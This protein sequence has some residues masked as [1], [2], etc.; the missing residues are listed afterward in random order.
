VTVDQIGGTVTVT[1]RT[2]GTT[3]LH[4]NLG[5]IR[6]SGAFRCTASSLNPAQASITGTHTFE[7]KHH[8][9]TIE[10]VAESSIRATE[11]TFHLTIHL[12]VTKNG[13][14]FFQKQW[15]LSEPRRLL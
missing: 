13:R 2:A 15:T 11:T 4:D 5:T 6:R 3:T 10:V 1:N 8:G 14:P 7:L 12:N 9:D